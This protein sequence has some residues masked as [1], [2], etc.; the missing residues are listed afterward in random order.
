MKLH[1]NALI[2]RFERALQPCTE[3]VR[4]NTMMCVEQYR[5]A[6][7]CFGDRLLQDEFTREAARRDATAAAGAL[8]RAAVF[9]YGS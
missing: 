5:S 9:G 8:V 1:T 7:V 4:Q 6:A 2:Q 3:S